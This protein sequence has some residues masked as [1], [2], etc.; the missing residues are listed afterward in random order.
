M[1]GS[2]W[3]DEPAWRRN[4]AYCVIGFTYGLAGY[5]LLASGW[6][7]I[8]ELQEGAGGGSIA[9][10]LIVLGSASAALVLAHFVFVSGQQGLTRIHH[11]MGNTAAGKA[12]NG[13]V[14]LLGSVGVWIEP[15]G[16]D[17]V[18]WAMRVMMFPIAV[19]MAYAGFDCLRGAHRIWK[20]SRQVANS[21]PEIEQIS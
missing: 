11:W 16:G 19:M 2:G 4:I 14:C 7:L 21:G 10:D 13:C 6:D 12:F 5:L 1:N 17:G 20:Q 9:F 8:A 15:S 3:K 18:G